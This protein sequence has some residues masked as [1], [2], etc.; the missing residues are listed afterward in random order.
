MRHLKKR[1]ALLVM[2]ALPLTTAM[3][4]LSCC[5]TDNGFEQWEMP[6]DLPGGGSGSDDGD[7]PDFDPTITGWDGQKADDAMLWVPT[8]TSTG[9]RTPSAATGA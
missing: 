2:A 7:T 3:V 8:R 1:M 9:R 4:G 5:T 6:G